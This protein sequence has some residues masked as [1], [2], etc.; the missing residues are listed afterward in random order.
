M[1]KWFWSVV[2]YYG[3]WSL[4]FFIGYLRIQSRYHLFGGMEP[5][6]VQ[7]ELLWFW[8][9]GFGLLFVLPLGVSQVVAGILSYRYAASHPRTW[10]S[11]LLGF[12]LCIPAIICCLFEYALFILL[13]A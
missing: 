8:V 5:S 1:K 10:I 2:I 7:H 4:M 6:P 12:V 13:F 9:S 11:L 3:I